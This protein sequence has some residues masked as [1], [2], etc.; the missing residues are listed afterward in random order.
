MHFNVGPCAHK[1][2]FRV[3]GIAHGS[4]EVTHI[5]GVAAWTVA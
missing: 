2:S 4:A 3:R 5:C 1:G